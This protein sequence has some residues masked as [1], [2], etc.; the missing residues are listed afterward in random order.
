M[1]K[2]SNCLNIYDMLQAFEHGGVERMEEYMDSV[3]SRIVSTGETA[4][5]LSEAMSRTRIIMDHDRI[6]VD[7]TIPRGFMDL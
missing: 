1:A 5:E 6:D 3:N 2:F 4:Y 7:D